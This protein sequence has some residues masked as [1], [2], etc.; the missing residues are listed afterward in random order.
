M[1]EASAGQAH[2]R[3]IFKKD[4]VCMC[5]LCAHFQKTFIRSVPFQASQDTLV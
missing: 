5:V 3:T 4:I 2:I 1:A